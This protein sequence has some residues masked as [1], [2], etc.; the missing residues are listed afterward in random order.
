MF[1]YQCDPKEKGLFAAIAGKFQSI[2]GRM[3]AFQKMDLK[4]CNRAKVRNPPLVTM[5]AFGPYP[6]ILQILNA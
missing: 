3:A 2:G 1:G 4:V 6:S 5:S